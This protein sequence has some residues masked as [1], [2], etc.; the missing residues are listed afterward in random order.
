MAFVH[1]HPWVSVVVLLFAVAAGMSSL[2]M[3]FRRVN[4]PIL[5][6]NAHTL[7]TNRMGSS[8][9]AQDLRPNI[10]H[11]GM[12]LDGT[13]RRSPVLPMVLS[14]NRFEGAWRGGGS[15]GIDLLT[16]AFD[17]SAVDI[18]LPSAGPRWTIGR[19]YSAVQ[20]TSGGSHHDSDGYMGV[21]WSLDT[22]PSIFLYEHAT[23]DDE[24]V[25]YV[26]Y[27]ANGLAEYKRVESSTTTFKGTNGAG[28]VFVKTASVST[29]PEYYTLT[30][31]AGNKITFF[32]FDG[33]AS[34]AEGQ[35]W[36]ME[37]PAGNVA[38]VG[39]ATTASTAISSG[40]TAY[41]YIEHAYD[42]ENRHY[43]FS[44]AELNSVVRLTQVDVE[45]KTGGSWPDS[46]TGVTVRASVAFS[47]YSPS[48]TYGNAGDLKTAEVTLPLTD[49]GN[50][51][52]KTTFYQYYV[53]GTYD[54]DTNPG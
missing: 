3:F 27:G 10:G 31:Q 29:E 26:V 8:S 46:G 36:K 2:G 51:L 13:M 23:D 25:L 15:D 19:S 24:D 6:I 28:G 22:A 9:L 52:I 1:R 16:G 32:G 50:E 4:D 54:E 43:K 12:N 21:N 53:G 33:Y 7:T 49:S 17:A 48:D 14:G 44:Y 40:Y 35:I 5:E 18:S 39:D 38:Y 47:Y 45:T 41:G 42:L 37:D 30:D 34:P 20:K 11:R